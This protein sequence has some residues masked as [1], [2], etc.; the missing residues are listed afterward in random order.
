MKTI[1]ALNPSD[2]LDTTAKFVR[3]LEKEGVE[4]SH[5]RRPIDSKTARRNLAEFLKRG[6]PKVREDGSVIMAEF[7]S[8]YD[9]ARRILGQ[10]LITPEEIAA[11]R[12]LTY[13]DEQLIAFADTL[14]SEDVLGWCQANG[15]MLVAGPPK[16]MALLEIRDLKPDYFYSKSGGWYANE[17]ERFSREENVKSTW[18]ALRKGPVPNSTRKTWKEQQTLLSSSEYVPNDAEVEWGVTTY[19]AVRG[20]SLLSDVY[21][22]TFSLDAGGVRVDVGRF[23]AEGVSVS[24]YWDGVRYG[25]LGLASAREI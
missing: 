23:V 10:D 21:V 9:L 19:K 13:T 12:G 6:C 17:R 20:I 15:F 4:W 25:F 7:E 18:L 8:S 3:V 24:A 2:V 11:V 5:Y 1:A 16:P 14:P 22:R